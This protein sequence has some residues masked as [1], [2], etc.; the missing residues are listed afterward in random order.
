MRIGYHWTSLDNLPL[1]IDGGWEAGSI[2]I[3]PRYRFDRANGLDFAIMFDLDK[4]PHQEAAQTVPW[5]EWEVI[6]QLDVDLF[7]TKGPFVGFAVR[8]KRNAQKLSSA[9][10]RHFGDP[11]MRGFFG[12]I[13]VVR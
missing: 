9:I 8:S 7:D 12:Q 4:L 11:D 13:R 6:A 10:V 3:N 5:K 2:T 1:I